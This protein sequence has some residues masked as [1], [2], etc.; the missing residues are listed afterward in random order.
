MS[1]PVHR[2]EARKFLIGLAIV[3]ALAAVGG[4][5]AI[6]QGGGE[7][8]AKP[9]TYVKAAF[10]DVGT[11][12]HLQ[13]VTQNGIRVGT[14]SG[15][16]YE[17]GLAVVTLRLDGRREI[18]RDARASVGTERVRIGNESALGRRY[19]ELDPGEEKSGPLGEEM[20]PP[21][22]T[23][24]PGS[25]NDVFAAFDPETRKA[26]GSALRELGG[27][28]ADHSEDLNDVVDAAP[29]LLNDL[30]EVSTAVASEDADVPAL[31]QDTNRLAG[32]F[33][34]REDELR[35][36]LKQLDATFAAVSVDGADPLSRTVA[37]LPATLRQARQGLGDVNEPLASVRS[38]MAKVRPGAAALGRSTEDLRGVFREGARPLDK[39]APASEKARP[40]LDELTHVLADARP[41]A[42][43]VARTVA[44]A[45]VFLRGAS[46]YAVDMGM[47][48]ASHDL[49][50]GRIAPGKH[51]FSAMAAA[52]GLFNLSIPDPAHQ[53]DYYPKPG[54]GAWAN[55]PPDEVPDA[56]GERP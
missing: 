25:V 27:G 14:V 26:M 16:D 17:N 28:L 15:I 45:A 55:T 53:A 52:P 54:G 34:G 23:G 8:P 39:L 18:Y 35:G 40:G 56:K 29:D 32:R 5:G 12:N 13:N 30:G 4:I 24:S 2:R 7:L 46:P 51:Y 42:P 44:D 19:I 48:F 20:I 21:G 38:A 31:L 3:A 50:S 10:D 41:L 11:L 37:D 33:A 43:Q 22:R 49:L 1:K 36:L 9:Y 47:F 6:V